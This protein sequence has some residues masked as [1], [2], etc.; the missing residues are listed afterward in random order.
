MM[1]IRP[2]TT[3]RPMAIAHFIPAAT[4]LKRLSRELLHEAF[5][6]LHA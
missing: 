5:R 1:T 2:A 6:R 3:G 4:A